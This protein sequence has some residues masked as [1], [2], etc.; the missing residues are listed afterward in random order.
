MAIFSQFHNLLAYVK[1]RFS[2][3][4]LGYSEVLSCQ[5]DQIAV[6]NKIYAI[7]PVLCEYGTIF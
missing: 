3:G 2:F 4:L 1:F 7:F 6:D 5:I